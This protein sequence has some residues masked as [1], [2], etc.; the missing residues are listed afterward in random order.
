MSNRDKTRRE[1]YAEKRLSAKI[2]PVSIAT[3]SF[4]HEEN[5]AYVVRA[6]ACFGAEHVYVIGSILDNRTLRK[7]SGS[8]NTFINLSTFKNVYEFLE[9][10]RREQIKL[11]SL[12]LT[13]TSIPIQEYTFD[14]NQRIC[15]VVG[16]EETGVPVD[17][18]INSD[19]IYIPMMSIGHCLNTAQTA[20]IALYE[21]V[22]RAQ[23][24]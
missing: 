6:A 7:H 15:F 22:Q 5:L 9:M 16:H 20:N 17:I 10:T 3:I 1:R 21:Y 8:I 19:V 11:I 4:M 12:E 14:K 24:E 2:Y 18:L 23:S 13:D